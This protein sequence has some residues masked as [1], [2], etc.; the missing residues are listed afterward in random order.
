MCL[1]P[2][3]ILNKKYLPT[4]KNGWNPP[5]CEDERVRRVAVGCGKCIECRKQKGNE[6]KVRLNE[7]I[8]A[9]GRGR[10]VTLSFTDKSLAELDEALEWE[11]GGYMRENLIATLAIR[12]FLE[13]WRKKYGKSVKH[14][15]VTELGQEQTER[16]HLHGIIWTDESDEVI[17]DRWGYG[18]IWIGQW[19]N[20]I[21]VN[22]IVK[23]V[24]KVDEKH[25]EFK[26]KVLSSKGIGKGY[27]DRGDW[28]KN[29]YEKGA[30]RE[31]YK[32]RTGTK[33]ALPI[34]YRN[35]IYNEE[36]REQLWI[37]KQESGKVWVMGEQ[38]DIRESDENYMELMKYY[39]VINKKLGYGS[40]EKN[41]QEIEYQ[42]EFRRKQ[43]KKYKKEV[44]EKLK[45]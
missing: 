41:W 3:L 4:K 9:D 21:T 13:R 22:Y 34:Y 16:V 30:T 38:V 28:K 10:F 32:T 1:Y 8:R 14:W 40:D 11:V 26:S 31:Y 36:E 20:E 25:S 5:N 2:R 18:N 33:L 12:R 44:K 42:N 19:V 35:K 24:S 29:R 43:Y 6:W 39:R 7:E 23:Y 45:G 17:R 15:L 27:M 37:E